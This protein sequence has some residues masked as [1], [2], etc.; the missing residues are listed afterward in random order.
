MTK[1]TRKSRGKFSSHS[2]NSR[3]PR[4]EE[5]IRK[6]NQ[7]R[8]KWVGVRRRWGRQGSSSGGGTSGG[9]TPCFP[10]SSATP[11]P[12]SA[13]LSLHSASTLSASRST[14]ASSLPPPP[15]PPLIT[16]TLILSLQPPLLTEQRILA[17]SYS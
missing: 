1:T 4:T 6:S 16:P 9:S 7:S 12:A 17:V 8:K 13:S 15:P 2:T 10:I 5:E 14:T 3:E 11:L